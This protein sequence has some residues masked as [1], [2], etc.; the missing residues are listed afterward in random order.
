[1]STDAR[2][3]CQQAQPGLWTLQCTDDLPVEE[4]LFL[5]L[6][7]IW[8]SNSS[9]PRGNGRSWVCVLRRMGISLEA[10]IYDCITERLVCRGGW[11]FSEW[12]EETEWDFQ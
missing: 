4:V 12:G 10:N 3:L 11:I 8:G 5:P 7:D 6:W 1:M 9:G 2:R